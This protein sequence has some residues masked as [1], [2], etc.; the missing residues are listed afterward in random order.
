MLLFKAWIRYKEIDV[1]F[2][3]PA[4]SIMEAIQIGEDRAKE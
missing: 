3:Y 4:S 1:S 2:I